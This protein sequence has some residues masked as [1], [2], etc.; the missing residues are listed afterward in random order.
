MSRDRRNQRT[1]VVLAAFAALM[2]GAAFAAVPLYDVFCKVTGYGG[3]TQRAEAGS[4]RII[5]REIRILFNA[6]QARDLPWQF[7]PAQREMRVKV[8]Q[9]RLAF[10]KATNQSNETVT[11][12]ATYNVTPL[13]AGIYFSKIECFCFSEQVLEAGQEVDMP[14]SFFID[15]EIADDPNMDHVRTI[16]LSYTFYRQDQEDD[17]AETTD[18]VSFETTDNAIEVL[19]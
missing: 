8:G 5:D 6:D 3:T 19:N 1:F 11:G 12:V 4:D 17:A 2:V 9:N 7:G 13:T 14:V 10:Y 18:K 16:T 15:P